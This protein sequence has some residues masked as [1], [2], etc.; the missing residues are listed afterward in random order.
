MGR[1]FDRALT[2]LMRDIADEVLFR[3]AARTPVDTGL[4][5]E[6]WRIINF[7]KDGFSITNETDYAVYLEEGTPYMK[8]YHMVRATMAEAQEITD[9]CTRRQQE[10]GKE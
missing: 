5:Q 9:L 10:Q 7:S 3:V 4:A 8:P 1:A 6:S 2:S